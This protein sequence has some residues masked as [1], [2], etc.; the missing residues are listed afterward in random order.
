MDEFDFKKKFCQRLSELRMQKGISARDMSLSMG[1]SDSYINKIENRKSL[2][3][4]ENFFVICEYLGIE[5][6][7]FFDNGTTY[8]VI[9]NIAI[10]ELQKLNSNQLERITGIM[11]DINK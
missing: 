1:Q 5:P 8:P 11:K 2:P 4:M 3:S 6:K 10:E 9:V 7:D